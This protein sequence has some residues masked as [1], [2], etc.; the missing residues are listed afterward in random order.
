MPPQNNQVLFSKIYLFLLLNYTIP[1]Q[2]LN[3]IT[4]EIKR[5]NFNEDIQLLCD[6]SIN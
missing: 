5:M 2:Y 3:R 6:K 1:S 4:E